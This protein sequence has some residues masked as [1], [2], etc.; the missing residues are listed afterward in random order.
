[1]GLYCEST[2]ARASSA[3]TR[4]NSF[5]GPPPGGIS[6]TSGVWWHIPTQPTCLTTAAA[7][8]RGQGPADGLVDL[9]AA[10]GH[11]ARPQADADLAH[12]AVVC[13]RRQI[14]GP[15]FAVLREKGLDHLAG[16]VRVEVA[17]GHIVDLDHR[18]QRAAAQAGD[19]LDRE[20]P[21]GIGI[22][23]AADAQVA[24]Q[25][26][27]HQFRA[28][29]VAGRAV[30]DAD[31]V[32]ADRPVAELCVK[33]GNAR[34]RRRRDLGQPADSL[35]GLAGQVAKMRLDGLQNG[36]HGLGAPSQTFDGFIDELQI[37]VVHR[38]RGWEVGIVVGQ[39]ALYHMAAGG[40]S[41][42]CQP[43]LYRPQ[44]SRRV[45]SRSDAGHHN[46]LQSAGFRNQTREPTYFCT[47][48]R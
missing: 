18:G 25:G 17:V 35:H 32:L 31:D 3:C 29:H 5:D 34:D 16:A 14:G 30:A 36:D 2:I 38:P 9:P 7:P 27:L 48:H 4:A 46:R 15:A 13:C 22:V 8:R 21:L 20:Q 37:A 10:Q 19:L 42:S 1:M 12:R 23:A 24:F 41:G 39:C 33:C 26:V 6:S 45:R 11:A 44:V 28:L 47:A 40:D 43:T